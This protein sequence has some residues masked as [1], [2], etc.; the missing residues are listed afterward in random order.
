MQDQFTEE[1]LDKQIKIF[2]AKIENN[3]NIILFLNGSLESYPEQ[4]LVDPDIAKQDMIISKKYA[5][6]HIAKIA[7]TSRLLTE[8]ELLASKID[9]NKKII[10]LLKKSEDPQSNTELQDQIK[11]NEALEA[12][13]AEFD[14][15]IKNINNDSTINTQKPIKKWKIDQTKQ[16]NLINKSQDK[17]KGVTVKTYKHQNNEQISEVILREKANS[18]TSAFKNIRNVEIKVQGNARVILALCGL[19]GKK[20]PEP[21]LDLRYRK[22]MLVDSNLDFNILKFDGDLAYINKEQ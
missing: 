17:E 9:I 16:I 18:H 4:E 15:G 12:K 5:S 6:D 7:R 2:E 20:I 22:G 21:K 14:T 3:L 19:D 11:R 10:D 1:E 13:I 8:K